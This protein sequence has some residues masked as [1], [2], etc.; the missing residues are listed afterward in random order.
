MIKLTL[1]LNMNDKMVA[2]VFFIGHSCTLYC[3]K[4]YASSV[5]DLCVAVA[6][7]NTLWKL[8]NYYY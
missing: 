7:N 5:I 4:L 1:A 2:F 6:K 3:F 8:C